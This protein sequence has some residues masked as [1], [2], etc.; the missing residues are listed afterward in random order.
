MRHQVCPYGLVAVACA[1]LSAGDATAGLVLITRGDR[2]VHLGDVSPQMRAEY[3]VSRVGYKYSYVGVFWVDLWTFEGTYCVYDADRYGP[4]EPAAAAFLLGRSDDVPAR[5]FFYLCPLGWLILGPVAGVWAAVAVRDR[6]RERAFARLS[7]DP[8]YQTALRVLDAEY[9]KQPA[10]GAS[11]ATPEARY[12][13]ALDAAVHHLVAAGVGRDEA[14]RNLTAMVRAVCQ[15]APRVEG[16]PLPCGCGATLVV[17]AAAAG[18]AVTCRCGRTVPVPS[19]S[20]LNGP[21]GP[22]GPAAAG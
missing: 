20:E 9:A 1:L 18:S 11:A 21:G 14:E 17:P 7:Q 8:E 5:P 16:Y 6:R 4:I 10:E 3:K 2:V 19:L 15:S 22:G 13:T 12:R